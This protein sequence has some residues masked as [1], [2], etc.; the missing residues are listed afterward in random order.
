ME[1]WT[2]TNSPGKFTGSL[3]PY[4]NKDERKVETPLI[5]TRNINNF[6][7]TI[8]KTLSSILL[9]LLGKMITNRD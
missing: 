5:I 7:Y 1:S 4:L 8:C 3:K 6:A 2:I 9:G